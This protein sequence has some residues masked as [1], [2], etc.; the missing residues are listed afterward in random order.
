MPHR[1]HSRATIGHCRRWCTERHVSWLTEIVDLY[2][3]LPDVIEQ[4]SIPDDTAEHKRPRKQPAS[5]ALMR[6]A[7]WA[8]IHDTARLF[9]HG[10]R[11]EDGTYEEE[12]LRGL[13]DVPEV[14]AGWAQNTVDSQGVLTDMM[15]TTVSGAVALLKINAEHNATQPWIDVY[16][17]ELYWIRLSL[18]NAHA[19]SDPTP[20]GHCLT[21]IDG[22]D[23][24]G[25]VQ[26]VQGQQPK[27][28]RCGRKYGTLDLV[29]LGKME[30]DAKRAK[31]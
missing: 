15:L 25:L 6:L 17:A 13:P 9:A 1:K 12:Y 16:D 24:T 27:C 22:R 18:R 14:L 7:A 26:P 10:D 23:C 11:L 2:A 31:V 30:I 28:D 8:M 19:I 20:L 4:G 3:T 21:V 5:P 29:R